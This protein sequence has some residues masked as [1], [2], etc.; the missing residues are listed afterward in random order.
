ML[1]VLPTL[2][3]ITSN[4][5]AKLKHLFGKFCATSVNPDTNLTNETLTHGG[6]NMSTYTLQVNSE[7]KALIAKALEKFGQYTIGQTLNE[8]EYARKLSAQFVKNKHSTVIDL[9]TVEPK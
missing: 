5:C 7:Q 3:I 1:S 9:S 4:L 6:T 8:Q 2:A